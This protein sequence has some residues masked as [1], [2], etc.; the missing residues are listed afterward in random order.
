MANLS[1]R[2]RKEQVLA[3]LTERM[4]EW[5]DGPE[6]SNEVIGGSEGLKRFRELR[7]EGYMVQTRKHPDP[8]RDIFQYRLVSQG[9]V[10]DESTPQVAP[11]TL[12]PRQNLP[13]GQTPMERYVGQ[14]PA[15]PRKRG[16]EKWE[17]WRTANPITGERRCTF[18]VQ[19]QRILGI[20]V[21]NIDRSTWYWAV[22]IPAFKP[23]KSAYVTRPEKRFSGS[24]VGADQYDAQ[25]A[26]EE[27]IGEFRTK[28][29]PA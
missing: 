15:M 28:G 25:R 14:A 10:Y 4:G 8:G 26:V 11:H 20:V 2:T 19:K 24:L 23:R 3:Y 27:K 5:V 1:D 7:Q 18:W 16:E 22:I 21:P 12:D 13:D 17:D 29:V 9:R 6:I